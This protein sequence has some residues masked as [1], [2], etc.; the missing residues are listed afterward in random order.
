VAGRA[1]DT[2]GVEL[3]TLWEAIHTRTVIGQAT[4]ILIERYTLLPDQAFQMIAKLS[5]DM[6]KKLSAVAEMVIESTTIPPPSPATSETHSR[7]RKT[8]EK[9]K[10]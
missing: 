5:Q 9:R 7:L 3:A 10:I 6:N 4:G 2:S 8:M 1:T